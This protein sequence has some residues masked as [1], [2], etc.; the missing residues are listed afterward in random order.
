MSELDRYFVGGRVTG[1]R[2]E[3]A[4]V[5]LEITREDGLAG[6]LWLAAANGEGRVVPTWSFTGAPASAA[7]VRRLLDDSSCVA[8]EIEP[9]GGE[10]T[11]A[12]REHPSDAW[13]PPI[14]VRPA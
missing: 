4:A 13:S 2:R 6:E 11:V 14:T 8:V 9:G 1:A 3:P 10:V 12:T 7:P 5:V